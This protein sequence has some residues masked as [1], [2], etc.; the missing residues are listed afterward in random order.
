MMRGEGRMSD[1]ISEH[2]ELVTNALRKLLITASHQHQ[3]PQSLSP[4]SPREG[5]KSRR[6]RMW[7]S[8]L[9]LL[10]GLDSLTSSPHGSKHPLALREAN[11][12]ASRVAMSLI[13]SS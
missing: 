10:P 1:T 4:P 8:E 11:T 5:M 12:V 7:K 9:S 3:C 13:S 2:D 6:A